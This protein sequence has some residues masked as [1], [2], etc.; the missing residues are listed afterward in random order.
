[1]AIIRRSD[2]FQQAPGLRDEMNRLF[3]SFFTPAPLGAERAWTT[4]WYPAVDVAETES[5]FLVTAEIP[6][7]T[8]EDVKIDLTGNV[9]TLKGEKKE[10]KDEKGRN[11]HRV[12][13]CF[14]SF[15]RSV[16]LPETIDGERAKASYENGVLKIEVAKSPAARP[17]QIKVDVK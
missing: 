16:Q 3:D 7:M 13:R 17:R 6:G 14:G 5:A 1:M 11:W 10:E 8:A 9:L 15:M 4:G 2:L 12:E